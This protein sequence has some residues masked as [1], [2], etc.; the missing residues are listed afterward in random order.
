MRSQCS[1][2]DSGKQTLPI[3]SWENLSELGFHLRASL[4]CISEITFGLSQC[5]G[6]EKPSFASLAYLDIHEIRK[7]I[8]TLYLQATYFTDLHWF[9]FNSKGC[10]CYK[11][12]SGGRSRH[13]EADP[14][15]MDSPTGRASVQPAAWTQEKERGG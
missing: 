7:Q 1:E 9:Y 14:L 13:L 5:A 11:A 8:T 15:N 12:E 6:C 3:L 10:C 2:F 4:I